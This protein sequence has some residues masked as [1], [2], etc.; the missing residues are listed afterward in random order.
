MV[1]AGNVEHV[2][3]MRTDRHVVRCS[4]RDGAED[5]WVTVEYACSRLAGYYR[6]DPPGWIEQTIRAGT[7]LQTISF[8]Y[9]LDGGE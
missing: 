8:V 1:G 5:E 7:P 9:R 2:S 6:D 3:P 4:P